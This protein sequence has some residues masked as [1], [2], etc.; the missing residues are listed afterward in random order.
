MSFKVI[1]A[2]EAALHIHDDDNVGFGG[3]TAAGTPKVVPQAIARRAEEEHA[4]GR[5]FRIGVFTG[6]STSDR[7]DGALSRAKAIKFRTPYQSC[8][9]RLS[10]PA[11]L[12]IAMCISRNWR[13]CCVTVFW[14][15]STSPLSKR[16]R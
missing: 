1:S 12:P 7:L 14:E 3:F 5:P 15:K 9:V 11:R 2:E 8:P 6:A 16:H 13:K 10:M 4:A